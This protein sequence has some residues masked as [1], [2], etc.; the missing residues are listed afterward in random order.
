MGY[1]REPTSDGAW[2][3]RCPPGATFTICVD[4]SAPLDRRYRFLDG[5]ARGQFVP[6]IQIDGS[7]DHYRFA[8]IGAR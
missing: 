1:P 6:S 7:Y 2:V 3:M 8:K 4:L 5:D